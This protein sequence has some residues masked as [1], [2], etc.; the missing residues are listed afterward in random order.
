MKKIM[1]A[2]LCLAAGL[3]LAQESENTD[4][5]VDANVDL[6]VSVLEVIDVTADKPVTDVASEADPEVDA[7][8]DAIEALDEDDASE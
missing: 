2:G 1:V 5:D 8:L 6:R 7:I 3:A 4:T